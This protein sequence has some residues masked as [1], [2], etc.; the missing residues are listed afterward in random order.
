MWPS[1]ITSLLFQRLTTMSPLA[2]LAINFFRQV[3]GSVLCLNM[4]IIQLQSDHLSV[5]ESS[6]YHEPGWL[7]SS[8]SQ[9][10]S[11]ERS[12]QVYALTALAKSLPEYIEANGVKVIRDLMG[13]FP[14]ETIAKVSIICSELGI[15]DMN[16]MTVLCHPETLRLSFH[17]STT[18]SEG[19]WQSVFLLDSVHALERLELVNVQVSD[20]GI[21]TLLRQC[22]S[23][24]HISISRSHLSPG[25]PLDPLLFDKLQVLDVSHCTWVDETFLQKTSHSPT[26]VNVRNCKHLAPCIVQHFN[27]AYRGEPVVLSV[28]KQER[29]VGC[30]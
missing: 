18:I 15:M 14:S 20:H 10:E 29:N 30:C 13:R 24:T 27:L 12:L 4:P 25:A 7:V 6:Q 19:D 17:F 3:A 23:L 2:L 28:K 22:P 26:Y 1:I 5:V 9:M 11:S 21:R 16:I 8:P